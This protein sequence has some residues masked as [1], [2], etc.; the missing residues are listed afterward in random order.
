MNSQR[1]GVNEEPP[2]LIRLP[3]LCTCQALSTEVY[4]WLKLSRL[5]LL[6]LLR[7]SASIHPLPK[8]PQQP[9]SKPPMPLLYF[10]LYPRLARILTL[11]LPSRFCLL[12]SGPLHFQKSAIPSRILNRVCTY[13]QFAPRLG[14]RSTQCSM[15]H[16]LSPSG[17]GAGIRGCT[18]RGW[19]M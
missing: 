2:R 6:C 11:N 5:N 17:S 19:G 12:D 7:E 9:R 15:A 10:P 3:R 14:P 8:P 4:H 13:S 18:Y 1:G 16:H